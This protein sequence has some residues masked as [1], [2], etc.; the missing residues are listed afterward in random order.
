MLIVMR[1]R[2]TGEENG[3]DQGSLG[4]GKKLALSF[5]SL[6]QQWLSPGVSD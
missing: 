5:F 1:L 4:Q 2:V 3:L 6:S